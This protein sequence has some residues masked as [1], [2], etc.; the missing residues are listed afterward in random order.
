MYPENSWTDWIKF[1]SQLDYGSLILKL[2]SFVCVAPFP[3]QAAS[4]YGTSQELFK[5]EC[6]VMVYD[7]QLQFEIKLLDPL[8]IAVFHVT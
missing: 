6:D 4:A 7:K 2:H 8:S 1:I 5:K 3:E